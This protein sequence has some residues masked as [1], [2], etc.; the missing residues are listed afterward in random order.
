MR[1]TTTGG[2]SIAVDADGFIET[3]NGFVLTKGGIDG[4]PAT[5]HV[6]ETLPTGAGRRRTV[7]IDAGIAETRI[8]I[9]EPSLALFQFGLDG[10]TRLSVYDT[11]APARRRWICRCPSRAAGPV[12]KPPALTD[13]SCWSPE[14]ASRAAQPPQASSSTGRARGARW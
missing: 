2:D 8:G 13:A 14:G 10:R 12:R 5:L 7:T 4:Q 11:R 3:E 6:F 1:V 9:F